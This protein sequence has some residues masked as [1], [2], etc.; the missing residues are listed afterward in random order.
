[1]VAEQQQPLA[2]TCLRAVA[3]AQ[4][5]SEVTAA[6]VRVSD[7]VVM[8]IY[9][10]AVAQA[11]VYTV[12]VLGALAILAVVAL[13]FMQ[14][15]QILLRLKVGHL[16]EQVEQVVQWLVIEVRAAKLAL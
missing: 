10:V 15:L 3:K 8:L 7:R 2:R 16:P 12:V 9:M 4:E 6:A 5:M 13:E 14:N 1:V 11:I